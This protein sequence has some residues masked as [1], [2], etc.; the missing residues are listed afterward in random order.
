MAVVQHLFCVHT[1]GKV[2]NAMT[3]TP[4]T[5][6]NMKSP[7]RSFRIC[8][9]FIHATMF[10][11]RWHLH[12][13]RIKNEVKNDLSNRNLTCRNCWS[14]GGLNNESSKW[15]RLSGRMPQLK[16]HIGVEHRTRCRNWPL[17]EE[18]V[19]TSMGQW[20]NLN[21]KPAPLWLRGVQVFV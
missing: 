2:S 7:Q 5:N 21:Q 19:P 8:L 4:P 14:D 18:T 15:K 6:K 12:P 17:S 3:L 9:V 20:V 10:P 1:C 11:T 13:P 16:T